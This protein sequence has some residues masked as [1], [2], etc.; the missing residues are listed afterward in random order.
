MGGLLN[1]QF[2][3]LFGFT[4]SVLIILGVTYFTVRRFRTRMSSSAFKQ[5]YM[6]NLLRTAGWAVGSYLVWFILL[7]PILSKIMHGLPR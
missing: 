1:A 3:A 6:K 5:L 4:L 2:L 7:S